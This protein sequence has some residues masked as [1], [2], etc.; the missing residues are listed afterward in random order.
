[1][2]PDQP[3][4]VRVTGHALVSEGAPHD[5]NGCRLG[6]QGTFGRG[7]AKCSC[8]AL[9]DVLPSG[10]QRKRWHREHKAEVLADLEEA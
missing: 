6:W 7:R 2:K 4:S 8:G 5:I 9:S 3:T 1:M 10:Y